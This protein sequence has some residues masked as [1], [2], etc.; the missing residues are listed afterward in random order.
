MKSLSTAKKIDLTK[1]EFDILSLLAGKPNQVF[2]RSRIL[3]HVR[4]DNYSIT[5]RVVDYQ[6][7]GI[8]KSSAKPE[9]IFILF[10]A[11]DISSRRNPVPSTLLSRRP[12]E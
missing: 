10:A 5:E 3:D 12:L 6:I 2:T 4:E 8:E 11:S 9:N 7:T 1:T